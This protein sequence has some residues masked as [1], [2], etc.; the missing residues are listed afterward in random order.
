VREFFDGKVGKKIPLPRLV[1]RWKRLERSFRK[2]DLEL[3]TV[4][5][6]ILAHSHA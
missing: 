6:S 5:C 4:S 3:I 1:L 2:D